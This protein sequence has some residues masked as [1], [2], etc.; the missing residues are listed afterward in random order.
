MAGQT[1][2][3]V[4]QTFGRICF[5]NFEFGGAEKKIRSKIY[6]FICCITRGGQTWANI[7]QTSGMNCTFKTKFGGGNFT[8]VI[9]HV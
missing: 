3:N 8:Q 9:F 4:G 7:G 2:A 1:W 6:F 5:L